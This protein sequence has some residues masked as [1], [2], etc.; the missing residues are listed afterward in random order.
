MKSYYRLYQPS[1]FLE[2]T[3]LQ[4]RQ[5]D[6]DEIKASSG[7]TPKEALLESCFAHLKGELKMY[8]VIHRGRIEGI[9]GV[10]Y[11]GV[12]WF[13]ATDKFTEYAFRFT[14]VSKEVIELFLNEHPLIFNHVSALHEES[15][16]WL[17]WLGFTIETETPIKGVFGGDFYYFYL[18]KEGVNR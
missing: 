12:V 18:S 8:V 15:I 4:L 7:M 5:S 11:Q 9:F 3:N 13:L 14:K 10:T 16:R 17:K 6:I 1:D 2:V